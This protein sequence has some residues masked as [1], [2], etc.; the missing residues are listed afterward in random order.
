MASMTISTGLPSG[1][2]F[3]VADLDRMP[4][5]GNRYELIDGV[6]IVTPAPARRHQRLSMNL[7]VLLFHACP[8]E[9]EVLAAP[10]DVRLADDTNVQPDLVVARRS[11]LTDAN[12]PVAPV[13]AVEI[14][15]PS[16]RSIDLHVKRERLRRAGCASYWAIDPADGHLTAWELDE[17]GDYAQVADIRAGE[18][19]TAQRP[20]PVMI[21]PGEL[22][23]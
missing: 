4:D 9:L 20:F 15:S 17:R 2:A 22:L 7:S 21:V 10:F 16:T 1:R 18:T 14:L 23:D 3:T 12:L 19:W 8:A 5:D 11:D 13:L 6:L